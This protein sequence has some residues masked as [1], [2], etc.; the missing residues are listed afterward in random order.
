LNSKPKNRSIVPHRL[1]SY[2]EPLER[3]FD[4]W[5]E[6]II[7]YRKQSLEITNRNDS[8]RMRGKADTLAIA[9]NELML[10]LEEEALEK[11]SS[12]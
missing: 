6:R 1:E 10:A 8:L 4:D 12:S 3:L 2:S 5:E 7:D 11:D 9:R